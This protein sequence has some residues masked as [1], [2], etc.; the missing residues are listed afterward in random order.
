LGK[1]NI[2]ITVVVV[3]AGMLLANAITMHKAVLHIGMYV[4]H[5]LK[6]APNQAAD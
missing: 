2:I 4:Q 6:A 5:Q 1:V 3:A